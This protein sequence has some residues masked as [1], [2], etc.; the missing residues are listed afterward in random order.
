MKNVQ[1]MSECAPQF[2][3]LAAQDTVSI[4][5]AGNSGVICVWRSC[6]GLQLFVCRAVGN[7]LRTCKELWKDSVLLACATELAALHHSSAQEAGA[8]DALH[9]GVKRHRDEASS[10]ADPAAM[11]TAVNAEVYFDKLFR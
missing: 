4:E 8:A 2:T 6:L 1:T 3:E 9:S 11:A 10:S 5:A 7:I